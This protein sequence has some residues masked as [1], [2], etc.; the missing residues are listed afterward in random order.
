MAHICNIIYYIYYNSLYRVYYIHGFIGFI[1]RV[2]MRFIYIYR[3]CIGLQGFVR[4]YVG[5]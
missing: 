3:D 5:L 1:Y 2:H 4:V